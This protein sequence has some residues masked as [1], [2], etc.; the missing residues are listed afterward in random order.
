MSYEQFIASKHVRH[1]SSGF[2]PVSPLPDRLF[3]WQKRIVEWCCRKGRSAI[4][5]D[6]GLGKTAMQLAWCDQVA[7]HTGGNVLL[8]TPISVGP[9]TVREADKFGIEGVRQ[10]R[11]QDEIDSSGRVWVTNYD[12]LHKFNLDSFAGV[13]LD[14]SSILKSFTGKI[15]QQLC[16]SFARTPYKLACT[17]TAAPNDD[18][19]LGNHSEFLNAMDRDIMLSK[20]FTHD[21]GDTSKWR[22]KRHGAKDFWRWVSSWAVCIGVPSDVGGDD[23]GF[24]LPELKV[25]HHCVTDDTPL[26][27]QLFKTQTQSVAATDVHNVKRGRLKERVAKLVEVVESIDDCC[28]IW[29][30]TD[31]EADEIRKKLDCVEVRGSTPTKLKEEYLNG[32]TDGKYQ[33]LLTKARIAG[34]G[35]NWQHC[36]N[37]VHF[38]TYSY[39]DAYQ[40]IRRHYRFG[41]GR[42]VNYHMVYADDELP[43]VQ[44][45]EEKALNHIKMRNAMADAMR[46]GMQEE[47]FG[48]QSIKKYQP[49][50]EVVLPIFM[51]GY[52]VGSV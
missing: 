28:T 8:L 32:F 13:C 45:V 17:A 41:Q 49:S 25:N 11:E 46:E 12:R 34:Y 29:V 14:E 51:E 47:L 39:E 4:F 22:L 19:E 52:Y 16:E 5:A 50:A 38:P 44:T 15:K 35:M 36:C 23:A 21:S 37:A 20:F 27:G 9:Q 42:A 31:Y 30:D 26:P 40:L 1:Q 10:V 48:G 2:D 3:D 18:M 43:V 24:I 33:R 6:C 7:R